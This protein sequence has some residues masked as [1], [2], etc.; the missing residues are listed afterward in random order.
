MRDATHELVLIWDTGEKQIIEAEGEEHA[1]KIEEGYLKA[2]GN[3]NEW[4]GIRPKRKDGN[5]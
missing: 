3:Q 5:K 1:Q 4:S 2:F